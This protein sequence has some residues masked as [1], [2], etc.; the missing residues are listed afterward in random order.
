MIMYEQWRHQ[1][2]RRS[3]QWTPLQKLYLRSNF[4]MQPIH[5]WKYEVFWE[6]RGHV[7]L[8]LSTPEEKC[9]MA[10]SLRCEPDVQIWQ[11]QHIYNWR[12]KDISNSKEYTIAVSHKITENF[13]VSRKVTSKREREKGNINTL[14]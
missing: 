4:I 8:T 14:Y 2:L 11:L 3:I 9:H 10:S 13:P 7:I 5:N 12:Y 1:Y 6:S